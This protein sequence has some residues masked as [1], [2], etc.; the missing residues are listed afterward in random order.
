M[1]FKNHILFFVSAVLMASCSQ[2]AVPPK[3]ADLEKESVLQAI[4]S[5]MLG[6][7]ATD[8]VISVVDSAETAGVIDNL[9][10]RLI[11]AKAYGMTESGFLQARSI[12]EELLQDP[13]LSPEDEADILEYLCYLC[14]MRTDDLGEVEYGLRFVQV[15]ECD[16]DGLL[17]INDAISKLDGEKGFFYLDAGIK[18][19]KSLIRTYIDLERYLDVVP[20]AQEIISRLED[21][22]AAPEAYADSSPNLPGDHNRPGYVDFYTA[23]ALAFITYAYAAEGMRKEAQEYNARFEKTRYSKTFGGR[24][25]ISSA[26]PL[27]GEYDRM[28][29]FYDELQRRWGADTLHADYAIMLENRALAAKSKGRYREALGYMQRYSSL[30]DKLNDSQNKAMIQDYVAKYRYQEQ[31]MAL[32]RERVA[33]RRS[34]SIALGASAGALVCLILLGIILQYVILVRRKNKAL[35]SQISENVILQREKVDASALNGNPELSSLSDAQLFEYLRYE[36]VTNNL[37]ADSRLDRQFLMDRYHLSK[38]R[39]G[40]AFSHGSPY[41]SLAAFLNV[42]RLKKAAK[43]LS[44]SPEMSISDVASACGFS[45]GSLFARNFK[46]YFALTPTEFRQNPSS[47]KDMVK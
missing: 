46:Q 39:I 4:S 24:K 32:E 13:H 23:Q 20:V 15:C 6:E 5:M 30:A 41:Q 11:R 2:P 45:S 28:L 33:V 29:S 47:F 44:S 26:W 9:H 42:V 8:D 38:E 16:E 25:M 10:A 17:K 21:Y 43:M 7:S 34:R 31:K 37:Y 22:A 12:C 35:V 19:R 36:I 3:H 27:L 14:R 40:S 18:T 1:F